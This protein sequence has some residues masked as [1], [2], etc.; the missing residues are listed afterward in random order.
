MLAMNVYVHVWVCVPAYVCSVCIAYVWRGLSSLRTTHTI[1]PIFS[2]LVLTLK[3][4]IPDWLIWTV[5]CWLETYYCIGSTQQ[6]GQPPSEW[7]PSKKKVTVYPCTPVND[8]CFRPS[9]L[10]PAGIGRSEDTKS[11]LQARPAQCT[12]RTGGVVTEVVVYQQRELLTYYPVC[13]MCPSRRPERKQPV[14]QIGLLRK[15]SGLSG[16]RGEAESDTEA[17]RCARI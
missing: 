8:S 10:E 17:G 9:G 5:I 1:T 6:A 4:I 3:R 13:L 14:M 12:V 16:R 15:S 2:P 7:G 11:L